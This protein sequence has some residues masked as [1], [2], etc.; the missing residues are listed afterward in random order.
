MPIAMKNFRIIDTIT[1]TMRV[2]LWLSFH[3]CYIAYYIRPHLRLYVI[4]S[5][6][7]VCFS[8]LQF[9]SASVS[10]NF[11]SLH[12]IMDERKSALQ[13]RLVDDDCGQLMRWCALRVALMCQRYYTLRLDHTRCSLLN[14]IHVQIGLTIDLIDCSLCKCGPLCISALQRLCNIIK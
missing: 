7:A 2:E 14:V 10:Y 3:C 9:P 13:R 8:L 5:Q 11:I 6:I 4:C 12:F 1:V